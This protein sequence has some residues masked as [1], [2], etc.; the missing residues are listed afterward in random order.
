[1]VS[2]ARNR[3]FTLVE[4]LVVI[5][6]IAILI[7]LLLPALSAARAVAQAAACLSN[8]R[9]H[10]F[11]LHEYVTDWSGSVPLGQEY[12]SFQNEGRPVKGYRD[13]MSDYHGITSTWDLGPGGL[14][15]RLL[16]DRG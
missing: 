9:Q 15:P 4:L 13:T 11:A 8:E 3:G 12:F 14:V 7:Y 16:A 1:M 6:V 5:A 10:S 2:F